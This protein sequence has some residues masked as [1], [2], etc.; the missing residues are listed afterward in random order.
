MLIS[1]FFAIYALY[2]GLSKEFYLNFILPIFILFIISTIGVA[3]SILHNI[4]QITHASII[5][6]FLIIVLAS[7]G[8]AQYFVKRNITIDEVLKIILFVILTNSIIILLELQFKSLR[9]IIEAYLDPLCCTINYVEGFRLRG[10]ASAGGAGLSIT[11]PTALTIALYL[12]H[13]NKLNFITLLISLSLLFVSGLVIGRTGV[14]LMIIPFLTYFI[15]LFLMKQSLFGNFKLLTLVVLPI[16]FAAPFVYQQISE[17]FS[18][19]FSEA[20][21]HYAFGFLLEGRNG[22]EKE[23]TVSVMTEYIQVLPMEFPEVLIGYGFYGGSYFSPW[24]DSGFARTLLSVGF[25][26]GGIF[27]AILYFIYFRSIRFNKYLL[28]TFIFL[29]TISEIKEPLLY[30]GFASRMFIIISIY[31]YYE[32]KLKASKI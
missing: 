11:V 10:L 18:N 30:S 27:Y 23:G 28:G 19:T 8:V 13:Q 1:G 16:T 12:F 25:L 20:F 22:I 14:I 15:S 32:N 21:V 7:Y 2:C 4:P 5:I 29:L 24:T 3:S 6:S 26:L 9:I 17:Y 31:Y